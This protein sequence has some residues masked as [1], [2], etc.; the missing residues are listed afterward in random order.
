MPEQ[1]KA[2]KLFIAYADSKEDE[3]LKEQLEKHLYFLKNQGLIQ[4]WDQKKILAGDEI[5]A[6]TEKHLHESQII[7]LLVSV[8]FFNANIRSKFFDLC[9]CSQTTLCRFNNYQHGI[10][11]I[12]RCS[13]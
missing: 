8:D 7:L 2:I 3:A 5:E 11:K 6:H 4:T 1:S 12:S 9:G 13:P 10:D